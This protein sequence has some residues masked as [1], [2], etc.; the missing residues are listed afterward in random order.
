MT[1]LELSLEL[2]PNQDKASW[3]RIQSATGQQRDGEKVSAGD[4]VLLVCEPEQRYLRIERTKDSEATDNWTV[5]LLICILYSV[6][7]CVFLVLSFRGSNFMSVFFPLFLFAFFLFFS[8]SLRSGTLF[9]DWTC[10][11]ATGETWSNTASCWAEP[12]SSS[13]PDLDLAW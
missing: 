4:D 6:F 8:L 1:G 5:R 10:I 11:A 7:G 13:H 9:C 2:V 3:F 12:L